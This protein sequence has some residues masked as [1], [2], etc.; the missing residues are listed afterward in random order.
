MLSAQQQGRNDDQQT[1][2]ETPTK[3]ER[4]SPAKLET[5][6][7]DLEPITVAMGLTET[8]A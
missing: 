8:V 7:L 1:G 2:P 4:P 6:T 5:D 3:Q